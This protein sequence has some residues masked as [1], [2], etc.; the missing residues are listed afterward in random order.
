MYGIRYNIASEFAFI[1]EHLSQ[2]NDP[3]QS[4][5]TIQFD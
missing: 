1:T 2:I 3:L 5:R 4:Q